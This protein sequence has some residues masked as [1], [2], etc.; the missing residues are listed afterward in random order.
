[1]TLAADSVPGPTTLAERRKC[2]KVGETLA[3]N[4][5]FKVLSPARRLLL[6]ERGSCVD[7]VAGDRLFARG[8]PSDAAY[9]III[10]EIEVSIPGLDGREVYLARL[11]AGTVLGEMGVLDGSPRSAD[12]R[13]TRKTE[14]WRID[15]SLVTEALTAEPGAAL[16]LL[17]VLSRRL[18]DTDALVERTA[19]MD[20]GKRLARLL[21][22]EGAKGRIT[23]NQSDIAHL[24]GATRE[25][26]NRKLGRWRK[27]GWV[28]LNNTGLHIRDRAALL[29]LCK[30]KVET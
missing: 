9:A 16:A 20:L 18:R 28:E 13:A 15:R 17:G 30:R 8:D 1:M 6:A 21:L 19:S 5:V 2:A 24:V 27:S 14:L 29:N 12:A 22:E 23:Y 4:I 10:G 25:A 3:R 11:G 7:L 26:V